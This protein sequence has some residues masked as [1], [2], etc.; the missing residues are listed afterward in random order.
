MEQ[1]GTIV[2]HLES[3][4]LDSANVWAD[5]RTQSKSRAGLEPSKKHR[6]R[7]SVSHLLLRS[8][9]LAASPIPNSYLL[10][11]AMAVERSVWEQFDLPTIRWRIIVQLM[12]P[13]VG[14]V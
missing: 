9:M 14:E 3:M 8:H 1:Y 13:R 12:G 6:A 7:L 10:S 5:V 4:P 2:Y 11:R